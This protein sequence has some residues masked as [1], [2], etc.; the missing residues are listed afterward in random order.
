MQAF[1]EMTR[2]KDKQIKSE[3]LKELTELEHFDMHVHYKKRYIGDKLCWYYA[4]LSLIAYIILDENVLTKFN[5][6]YVRCCYKLLMG[7]LYI[8]SLIIYFLY[9]HF[10]LEWRNWDKK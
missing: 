10:K 1:Y 5:T 7:I 4:K 8:L 6:L 3:K 9:I 2:L